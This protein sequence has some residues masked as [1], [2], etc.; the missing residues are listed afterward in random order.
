MVLWLEDGFHYLHH[1]LHVID[2]YAKVILNWYFRQYLFWDFLLLLC[3]LR[4]LNSE[5][6]F[7][8]YPLAIMYKTSKL[9]FW[10]PI[11]SFYYKVLLSSVFFPVNDYWPA[12]TILIFYVVTVGTVPCGCCNAIASC[13]WIAPLYIPWELI[14]Y[15]TTLPL[16]AFIIK[17]FQLF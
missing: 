2:M 11:S 9:C 16:C 6:W 3:I 13:I 4:H 8:H 12:N 14:W 17:S 15:F 10:I 5:P 1:Q 7:V